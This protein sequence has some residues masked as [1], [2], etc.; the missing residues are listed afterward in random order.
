MN[1]DGHEFYCSA[2]DVWLTDKVSPQYFSVI[3]REEVIRT[4]V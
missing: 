3:C 1:V 4:Q 2:N